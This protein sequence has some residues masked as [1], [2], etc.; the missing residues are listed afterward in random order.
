MLSRHWCFHADSSQIMVTIL[1]SATRPQTFLY[2]ITGG[3]TSSTLSVSPSRKKNKNKKQLDHLP[4]VKETEHLNQGPLGFYFIS[5]HFIWDGAWCECTYMCVCVYMHEW[6]CLFGGQS[7]PQVSTSRISS[8]PSL[9]QSLSLGQSLSVKL[10]WPV[11]SP[12]YPPVS[13][14]LALGLFT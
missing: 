12:G 7:Q 1:H 5:V 9:R 8:S 6:T 2:I 14:S 10:G 11:A 3:A 4:K 13:V